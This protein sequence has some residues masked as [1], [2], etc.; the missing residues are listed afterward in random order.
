MT[1]KECSIKDVTNWVKEKVG[2]RG[3][4]HE[5]LVRDEDHFIYLPVH[6]RMKD[7]FKVAEFLQTIEDQWNHDK[8]NAGLP[9]LIL[10]PSQH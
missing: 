5:Q 8:A 2:R 9:H 4:V 7:A 1:I 10:V 6:V 3:V